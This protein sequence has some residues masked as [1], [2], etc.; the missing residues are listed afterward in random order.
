MKHLD[1]GTI[2]AWL[3]GALDAARSREIEAH[4][5]ECAT[6]S[7]AVAEARG[8]IAASSR[9]LT[10]L[11]D[12]PGGVV[13]KRPAAPVKPARFQWRAAPWVSAIAATLVIAV[14]VA[15]LT[16]DRARYETAPTAAVADSARSAAEPPQ[17]VNQVVS[18][19]P[20]PPAAVTRQSAPPKPAPSVLAS[21]GNKR[22]DS[23]RETTL[24]RPTDLAAADRAGAAAEL[25]RRE[26]A[27]PPATGAGAAPT[28]AAEIAEQRNEKTMKAAAPAPAPAIP[29]TRAELE[30]IAATA[31]P[32]AGG[33][34]SPE[35]IATA[36]FAGCYRVVSP[37]SA[38]QP[39]AA[40]QKVAGAVGRASGARDSRA[41]AAAAA[42]Y[43][44]PLPEGG[45]IR[46]DTLRHPLGFTAR[47]A[48]SDE[49][50]GNWRTVGADSARVDL[51][52]A[53]LF[54]VALKNRVTCPER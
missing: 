38:A 53:G 22:M 46:L 34:R 18:S 48:R 43:T 12:V 6:C 24:R 32:E 37:T 14:G 7:A 20:A 25:R 41:P 10:A 40:T 44:T 47:D 11:D 19:Q 26:L 4:V 33:V 50:I 30:R 5:A 39:F 16:R 15:T 1:E 31:A 2:H 51:L 35:Q 49:S 54:T 21:V 17:T 29:T 9:I 28:A 45:I 42:D 27:A 3:D 8:L 23:L 13:P 36:R 52:T